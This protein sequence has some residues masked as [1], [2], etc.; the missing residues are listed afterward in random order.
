MIDPC[1]G[2]IPRRAVVAAGVAVPWSRL[3]ADDPRVAGLTDGT[4]HYASATVLA[5]A[6]RQKR[7]STGGWKP[8][9]L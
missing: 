7:V 9:P 6:I 3:L 8:P 4:L 2:V 5:E 1:G